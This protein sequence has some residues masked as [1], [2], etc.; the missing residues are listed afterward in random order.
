MPESGL[1]IERDGRGVLRLTLD[2]P[3]K[4][5]ALT[6][7]IVAHLID[8]LVAAGT[9]ES[10]RAVLIDATGDDFCSG[11]DIVGRNDTSAGAPRPRSAASSAGCRR[12]AT[13]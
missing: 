3:S 4:R 5:N 11:F 13:G 8:E 2:R 7:P 12:R 1:R 6:D 10:V 9:D